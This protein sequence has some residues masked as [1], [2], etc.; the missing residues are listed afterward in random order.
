MQECKLGVHAPSVFPFLFIYLF[1]LFFVSTTSIMCFVFRGLKT[2]ILKKV[3]LYKS[4]KLRQGF[5]IYLYFR[6]KTLFCAFEHN[7]KQN[8]IFWR[9]DLPGVRV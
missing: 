2:L 4:C 7:F 1:I 6:I 5:W 8:G 9:Q 3:L